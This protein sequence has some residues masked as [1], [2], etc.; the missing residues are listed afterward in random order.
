MLRGLV[1]NEKHSVNFEEFRVFLG[2]EIPDLGERV[3]QAVVRCVR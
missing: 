1:L 2:L 3:L